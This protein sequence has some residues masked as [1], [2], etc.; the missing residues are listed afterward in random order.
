MVV[1]AIYEVGWHL[2]RDRADVVHGG[3]PVRRDP[4]CL[5]GELAQH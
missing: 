1:T 2:V 3:P 4:I 5:L